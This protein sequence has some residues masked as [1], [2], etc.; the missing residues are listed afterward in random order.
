MGLPAQRRSKGS[1]LRRASHFALQGRSLTTCPRCQ[2]A[3]M[4]HRACTNCGYYRGR[5][6]LKM[7]TKLDKRAKK[8]QK[9]E[10]AEASKE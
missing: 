7:E 1:R 4:P 2:S 10:P 6:V 8:R 5:D 9:Q 3:I